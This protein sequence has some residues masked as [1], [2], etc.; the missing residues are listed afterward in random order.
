MLAHRRT[1]AA[2][3]AALRRGAGRR[4][5]VLLLGAAPALAGAKWRLSARVAPTQ[6]PQKG[7]AFVTVQA[8]DVG[9]AE[10]S[11][12][13]VSPSSPVTI[14]DTLPEGLTVTAIQGKPRG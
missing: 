6:L 7:D 1:E 12:T 10:V 13:P 11:A 5:V 4:V 8:I 2:P 14:T 9:D 3:A